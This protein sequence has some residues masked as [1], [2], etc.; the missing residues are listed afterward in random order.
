[1]RYYLHQSRKAV[2]SQRIALLF[3]VLFAVTF[4]LH[5]LGQMPTNV[6]MKLLG[7]SIVGAVLAVVLGFAALGGIWREGFT[8]AGKAVIGI[9]FGAA[10]LGVP[11][12]SMPNLLTLPRIYEVSTDI[13]NPPSFNKIAPLREGDGV[14]PPSFQES[15]AKLQVEAYPDIKPLP[16]DRPTEDAYSA[17]REAVKNMNWK[18]VAENPPADGNT[19]TIEATHRSLFFGFTDDMAIR[20]AGIGNGTRVDVHASARNGHHDLGRNADSVRELFSEVKTRL[21]EIDKNEKM[22]NAIAVRELRLK[23]AMEEKERERIAAEREE[24]RR[25][26]RAAALTR[27][28]QVSSSENGGSAESQQ[29]RGQFRPEASDAQVQNRR[30]RRSARTRALRKFWE[31][32]NQ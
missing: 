22:E 11:L 17:V 2:W 6:A 29:Q 18:I 28:S 24:A 13:R 31:Q 3:F 10:V 1:M 19:G 5:R 15:S 4:G 9:L 30:Q 27:E 21:S 23:K 25:R 26:A 7:V 32:L 14:N 16:I 12:W 8:G 20:V